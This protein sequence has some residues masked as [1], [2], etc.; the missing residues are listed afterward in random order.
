MTELFG[1]AA[2]AVGGYW[3]ARHLKRKMRQVESVLSRA[4]TSPKDREAMPN[5]VRDPL[6][7]RYRP[8]QH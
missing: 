1:I 7:G 4:T 6:T 2:L 8:E 3:A 5:L